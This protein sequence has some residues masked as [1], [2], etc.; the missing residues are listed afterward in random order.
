MIPKDFENADI[1]IKDGFVNM[2]FSKSNNVWD[3]K[4]VKLSNFLRDYYKL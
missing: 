4:K 3:F 2:F 1:R